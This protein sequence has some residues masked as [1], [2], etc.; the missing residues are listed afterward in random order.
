MI[1][2]GIRRNK[3]SEKKTDFVKQGNK[4]ILSPWFYKR[5]LAGPLAWT[6]WGIAYFYVFW[7]TRPTHS[8]GR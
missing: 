1:Q 4:T 8:H 7:S 2:I 3:G 5:Q 6:K